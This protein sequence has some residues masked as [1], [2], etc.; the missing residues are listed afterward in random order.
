MQ[1]FSCF[2]EKVKRYPKSND[3]AL[4]GGINEE[5]GD[6]QATGF[7]V[8]LA[9]LV[10]TVQLVLFFTTQHYQFWLYFNRPLCS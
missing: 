3:E 2:W 10:L 8:M 7:A 4:V 1:F 9:L 5:I 6:L